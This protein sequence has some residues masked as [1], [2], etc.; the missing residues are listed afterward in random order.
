[1]ALQQ[2]SRQFLENIKQTYGIYDENRVKPGIG[3]AT[4]VLLRRVPDL[5]LLRES[6]DKSVQHLKVLAEEKQVNIIYQQDLP[7][8]ATALIKEITH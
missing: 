8:S 5:L 4:R 6:N 3:E 1:M 7:Y 2:Q